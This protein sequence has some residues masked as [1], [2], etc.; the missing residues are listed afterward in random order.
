[1]TAGFVGHIGDCDKILVME[2]GTAVEFDSYE[3]SYE[4]LMR[5]EDGVFAGMA[6]K[7]IQT[8]RPNNG[9]FPCRFNRLHMVDWRC[10]FFSS[11]NKKKFH[12]LL[13][14]A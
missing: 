13:H 12:L 7:Q 14:K 1:M 11:R 8:L 5:K 10:W 2:G 6:K 3:D 4:E 9:L